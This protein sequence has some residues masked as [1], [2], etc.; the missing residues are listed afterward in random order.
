MKKLTIDFIKS[1]FEKEGYKLLTDEYKNAHQKLDYTCPNQHRRSIDWHNWSQGKRC[2]I[3]AHKK[4]ANEQRISLDFIKSEFEKVG[5]QLLTVEYKNNRQ[6]LDYICPNGHQHSIKWND[7]QQ[8][9]RCFYCAV[10]AKP[11]IDFIK[12]EFEK[13]GYQL[14]TTEYINNRQKLDYICLNGHCYSIIWNNWQQGE[15]CPTC[16]SNLLSVSNSGKNNPNWQGGISYEP[17]CPIWKDQEYK[18]DIRDRDGNM[19]LNP[20]CFHTDRRLHV[21][22]VDYNKKNCA[23]QNLITVCGG[24]NSRANFDRKWH[25][26]WYRTIL[27]KKYGYNYNSVVI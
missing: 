15:R 2:S 16:A 20:Y 18:A 21:H 22:H 12:S 10:V 17:Y 9:H 11:T 5:Y 26:T 19:C 8:G 25:T 3:C 1:E 14:L 13:E 24:C 6:K 4:I 23:L 7:W 27:N